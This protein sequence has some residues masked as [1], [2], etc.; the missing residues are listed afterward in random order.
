MSPVAKTVARRDEAV[1]AVTDRARVAVG[2]AAG[3]RLFVYTRP[4]PRVEVV[5]RRYNAA[6]S[7][8][9]ATGQSAPNAAASDR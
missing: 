4:T 5:G 2:V 9:R 8:V 7:A 6:T 3:L 1:R